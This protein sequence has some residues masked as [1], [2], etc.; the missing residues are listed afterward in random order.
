MRIQVFELQL[1][2]A[3]TTLRM[4]IH[5]TDDTFWD[6]L[7]QNNYLM[8]LPKNPL[9]NGSTRVG[10]APAVGTGWYWNEI[11]ADS[12]TLNIYAVDADGDWFD[13]DGDGLPD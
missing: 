7:V 10:D 12:W 3:S 4:I 5:T 2:D 6:A 8:A 11:G 1:P 9:Q 13:G